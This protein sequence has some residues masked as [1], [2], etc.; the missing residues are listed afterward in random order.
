MAIRLSDMSEPTKKIV[1][2]CFVQKPSHVLLGMKKRGFG[3]G[4]WNGFGGKLEQGETMEEAA[5]REL[6]EES[7]IRALEM[8]EA[9]FIHFDFED[10]DF[11]M[12][13]TLF[14]VLSH[15]GEPE[16][17]EEMKPQWFHHDDIPFDKMW[18]DDKFWLRAFLEGK[19]VKGDFTLDA[20]DKIIRHQ[21]E[22]T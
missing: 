22:I 6:F 17:T 18:D 9:G 19:S 12:E 3:M 11:T 8:K 7:G 16:E 14:R 5:R 13:V 21:L 10:R 15:E 20:K 1:T 2:L 4:R